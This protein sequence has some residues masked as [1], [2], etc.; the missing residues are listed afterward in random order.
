MNRRLRRTIL[1][2]PA[3]V[4]VLLLSLA[5]LIVMGAEPSRTYAYMQQSG[6]ATPAEEPEATTPMAEE[7]ATATPIEEEEATATP[8]PAEQATTAPDAEPTAAA[9]ED[10]AYAANLWQR[11]QEEGYSANWSTV[12]GK[13]TLYPGQP[14]HGAWLTTYLNDR[15]LEALETQPGAMP[16]G[17]VI[18]KENYRSDES[19]ASVTVMEKRAG[20]APAYNDWYYARYGPDGSVQGGGQIAS[21]MGC[22]AA[23]RSND[24][25]FTFVVAPV[26]DLA[27][28]ASATPASRRAVT[29]VADV[30]EATPTA[31]PKPLSDDEL[32][33][34]GE[35]EFSEYCAACHQTDGQGVSNVYPALT[36]NGFVVTDDPT[37]VLRVIFTGRA[38]MPHFRDALSAQE[39]AAIVSYIRNGWGNEAS[40]VTVEEVRTIEQEI[41]SPSEPMEHNGSG[42]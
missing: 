8:M 16:N 42:E 39:M 9:A 31:T 35:E 4:L 2:Q 15:A 24:Y 14:P 7:E 25:V 6:T 41:F 20:Y 26:D 22:H 18:I 37:N 13:G 30:P 19:L 3:V 1:I 34:M 27:A 33:S 21:C 23:V 28:L 36:R 5:A 29:P 11:L 10:E 40:T 32:I 38:G 17:A 12:P